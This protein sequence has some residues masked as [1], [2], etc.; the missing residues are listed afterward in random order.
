MNS[1][2]SSHVPDNTEGRS[3]RNNMVY[4]PSNAKA[5]AVESN[6]EP[7]TRTKEEEIAKSFMVLCWGKLVSAEMQ[8]AAVLS[9][10][11]LSLRQPPQSVVKS[12]NFST[13]PLPLSHSAD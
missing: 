11:K 4:M 1:L 2:I 3:V 5:F 13:S 12:S 8:D 10:L 7:R 9:I 6:W